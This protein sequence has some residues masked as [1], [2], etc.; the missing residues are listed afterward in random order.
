MDSPDL[1][2][3]AIQGDRD[4]FIR[5]IR[6]I[7]NLPGKAEPSQTVFHKKVPSDSA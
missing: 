6:E 5:L 4:A 3:L 2:K 7:E 1:I